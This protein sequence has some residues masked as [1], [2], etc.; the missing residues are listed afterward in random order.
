MKDDTK[1]FVYL[2]TLKKGLL[3]CPHRC[4]HFVSTINSMT[5]HL[6]KH[7][8]DVEL[9]RVYGL[10]VKRGFKEKL[11]TIF[12]PVDYDHHFSSTV[13]FFCAKEN[14]SRRHRHDT[15]P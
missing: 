4:C 10:A 13:C 11:K 9:K 3:S 15:K 1:C 14:P 5:R 6:E 8:E 7:E 12:T 2:V